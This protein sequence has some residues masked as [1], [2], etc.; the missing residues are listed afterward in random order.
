MTIASEVAIYNLALNAVGARDNVSAPT[1]NSRE[2]E[3]CRLWYSVVRDQILASAAW[4]EATDFRI[5]AQLAVEEDD[6]YTAGDPRTGYQYV[7]SLPADL[8][9]PQYLTD[10]GRF[11]ITTYSD[12]RR[13]LHTNTSY[14]VLAYTKRLETISLWSAELQM[15]IV[16]GLAAHVCM[17]L[18]GKPSRAKMLLAAANEYTM[19]ARESAANASAEIYEAIPDWIAA[20]GFTDTQRTRYFYPYGSLLGLPTV[21]AA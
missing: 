10:F 13:A 8:L 7:Y 5:L 1:E 9:R 2:A 4:P 18:S 17:P 19:A 14:A 21:A 12:N 3:V 11:L 16:Y 15:A 6:E 20:R